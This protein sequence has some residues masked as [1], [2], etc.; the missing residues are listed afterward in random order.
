MMA[1]STSSANTVATKSPKMMTAAIGSNSG[2]PASASGSSPPTVVSVVSAIGMMRSLHAST[3]REALAHFAAFKR[4]FERRV[5]KAVAKIERALDELVAFFACAPSQRRA[6]R[7][8]NA[9]ER[10]FVELRRRLRPMGCLPDGKSAQRIAYAV[11]CTYNARRHRLRV[12]Q[13]TISAQAA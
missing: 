8:T 3:R 4:R 11:C 2:P 5:P 10:V 12:D 6:G 9:I 1:G 13:E 7:T